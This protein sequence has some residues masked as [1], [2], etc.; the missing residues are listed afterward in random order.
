MSDDPE[1]TETARTETTVRQ[2]DTDG[3]LISETTTVVTQRRQPDD[4]L[5]LGMYL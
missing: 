3:K 1:L 4:T 5:P 2:F